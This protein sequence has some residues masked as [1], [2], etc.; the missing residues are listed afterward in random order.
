MQPEFGADSKMW[1]RTPWSGGAGTLWAF[2]GRAAP[3]QASRHS[4]LTD[5]T[6]HS[7]APITTTTSVIAL[8]FDGGVMMAADTLGSYGSLARFRNCP[9]LVKLNESIII[10]ASGDYADFQYLK[11]IMERKITDEECLDDGMHLKPKSLYCWLTRVLYNRRSK[12]DP[13]WN[14]YVVTGMQDGVPF[15][16]A[17]DKLG[18]AY[19]DDCIA[20][21]FGEYLA[22]P[23]FREYFDHGKV[24]TEDTARELI[25]KCMEVLYY[26]DARSYNR[27]E[28]SVIT[29]DGAKIEGPFSMGGDWS[30]A[31]AVKN[32]I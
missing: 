23:L 10:G 30:I 12:F 3:T 18:T 1:G 26:R 32:Y 19:E 6:K 4:T 15:L 2:P 22:R 24:L 11:D 5:Y 21:G 8:K 31:D 25:K 7:Q 16:G 27:Y 13:L 14:T 20:T 9:R 29:K 17:I 28:I